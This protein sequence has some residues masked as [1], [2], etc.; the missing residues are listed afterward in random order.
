MISNVTEKG[1]SHPILKHFIQMVQIMKHQA[2]NRS[3]ILYPKHAFF[4]DRE[5]VIKPFYKNGKSA[6]VALRKFR[7]EK[8]LKCE[9]IIYH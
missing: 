7:T 5:L 8:R 6:T 4:D 3:L 1:C 9:K 2:R